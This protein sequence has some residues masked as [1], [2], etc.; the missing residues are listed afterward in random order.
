MTE[1]AAVLESYAIARRPTHT[2]ADVA[3]IWGDFD[4]IEGGGYV[5]LRIPL[6]RLP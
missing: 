2:T 5:D 1:A 4:E 3:M 6:V